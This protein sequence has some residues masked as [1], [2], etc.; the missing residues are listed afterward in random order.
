MK[1]PIEEIEVRGAEGG[2]TMFLKVKAL[3]L[4]H[5]PPSLK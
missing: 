5:L 4:P 1:W 2:K 3:F